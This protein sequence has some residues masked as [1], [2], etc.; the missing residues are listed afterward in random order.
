MLWDGALPL[1]G[2]RAICLSVE[3]AWRQLVPDFA[4]LAR[5]VCVALKAWPQ[6]VAKPSPCT[7]PDKSHLPVPPVGLQ[8][9]VRC[10][11]PPALLM[12][13]SCLPSCEWSTGGSTSQLLVTKYGR[14]HRADSEPLAACASLCGT[15]PGDG[16]SHGNGR[17]AH[18]LH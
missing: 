16:S 12:R 3:Y 2:G 17:L 18:R 5:N 9:S 15:V 6:E 11:L 1:A 10:S 13:Q 8:Q 4:A 7:T 14:S